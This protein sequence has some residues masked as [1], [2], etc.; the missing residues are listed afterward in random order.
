VTTFVLVHG[1]WTGAHVWRRL[2]PLLARR[3]HAVLAPTLTG[4]GDRGHLAD[5]GVD[6]E[7]HVAEVAELLDRTDLHHVAL[8]AHSY[9]G[10]VATVV[11]D[12]RPYR[13]AHL[14]YVDALVPRDG[15][16]VNDLRRTPAP[17]GWIMPPGV[18]ADRARA[19]RML[20][21]ARL[22][23]QPPR[24]FSQPARLTRPTEAHAFHRTYVR[25]LDRHPSPGYDRAAARAR[26]QPGWSSYE[27]AGGHDPM[28][29]NP[30][31]LADVLLAIV[32]G[33]EQP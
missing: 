7:T 22:A 30:D 33:R 23:P 2:R 11:A 3:G 21:L 17:E 4:L 27:L 28:L 32:A 19:G 1:A 15:E 6:L 29:T 25:P 8:V 16:S 24:T 20:T 14:V 10:A 18:G 31:G 5:D 9:G 12:R 13:I 26:T